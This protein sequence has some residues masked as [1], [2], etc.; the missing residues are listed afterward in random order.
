MP[1]NKSTK[2]VA[3]GVTTSVL[4]KMLLKQ[5]HRIGCNHYFLI[6]RNYNHLHLR[7]IGRDDDFLTTGFVL[8][9]VELNAEELHILADL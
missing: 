3:T 6:S 9:L 5:I 4:R 2:K 7:V 1:L 8:L